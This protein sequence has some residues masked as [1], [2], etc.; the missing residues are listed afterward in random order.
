MESDVAV[1]FAQTEN[2]RLAHERLAAG[3]EAGVGAELRAFG[4]H[5]VHL[6]KGEVLLV[7]VLR[8]P[9]ARAAH[10][11]GARRVHEDNPGN[12]A[13]VL[14][15]VLLRLLE[16]AEAA[17]VGGSCQEGLEKVGVTLAQQ[18]LGVVRPLAVGVVCDLVQHLKGLRRPDAGVNFLDHVDKVVCDGADVL[19]LAFFDERV[20]HGL[21]G[22]ALCCMG[23]LFCC[24]HSITIPFLARDASGILKIQEERAQSFPS[25][26]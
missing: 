11:A 15:G 23:D 5:A 1:L 26:A 3:E 20:E 13:V 17:L 9:A 7:A 12:V 22:L 14:L 21:K 18:A 25:V 24:V 4:Q 6:L 8:R 16:A 10:V 2:V 19:R